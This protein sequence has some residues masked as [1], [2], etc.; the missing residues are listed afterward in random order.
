M[1]ICSNCDRKPIHPCNHLAMIVYFFHILQLSNPS[2]PVWKF[3]SFPYSKAYIHTNILKFLP[4][5]PTS[6]RLWFRLELFPEWIYAIYKLLAHKLPRDNHLIVSYLQRRLRA[7]GMET[8]LCWWTNS[9]N[10]APIYSVF[11]LNTPSKTD[12]NHPVV[13]PKHTQCFMSI[14]SS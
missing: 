7:P 9:K 11:W 13:H 10:S 8:A 3:H 4:T 2:P 12:F 14:T 5:N 6:M 1:A